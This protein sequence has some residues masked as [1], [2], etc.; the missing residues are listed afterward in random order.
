MLI[1]SKLLIGSGPLAMLT[2]ESHWKIAL[3]SASWMYQK[4]A[5]III[6][7]NSVDNLILVKK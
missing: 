3:E 7:I 5:G 1:T 2:I 6:S 4:H